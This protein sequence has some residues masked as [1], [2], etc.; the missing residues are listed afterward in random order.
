MANAIK[1]DVMQN[2]V[3]GS[4][5]EGSKPAVVAKAD[6]LVLNSKQLALIG[7]SVDGAIRADDLLFQG[8][9][10]KG[11]VAKAVAKV[12]KPEPKVE[13]TF[14]WWEFVA[15]SWQ[16]VYMTRNKLSNE[17]SAQNAW[18]D[19]CK[20]MKKDFELEKPKKP[21][22]DASRMS[23]KRKA[24]QAELVAKPD[25]VLREEYLAYKAEDTKASLAKATK[26][27]GELERR[28]NLANS[29]N[30]EQRKAKQALLAKAM[31]K[32]EDDELLNHLW[33]LV[34]QSIKLEIAQAK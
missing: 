1:S 33:G 29:S 32:I 17:K 15:T 6:D 25:S 10:L 20:R 16:N 21:T 31:K 12:L 26:L 24:E 23:E 8:D 28:E 13:P 34:P 5:A 22:A 3:N 4:V 11:I 2:V 14:A 30:I 27:K 19:V 7:E 18:Y 9:E